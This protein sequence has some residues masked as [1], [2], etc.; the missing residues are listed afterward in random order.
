MSM[1]SST[2]ERGATMVEFAVILPLLLMLFL[3]IA[4][5]GRALLFKQRLTQAVETGARYAARAFGSVDTTDCTTLTSWDAVGGV[6]D[7]TK[8]MVAFG[9]VTGGVT[10]VIPGLDTDDVDVALLSPTVTG[11][12]VVCVVQV[13]VNALP[14]QGI[15]GTSLI[16]LLNID[17]PTLSATS[18]ER[19]V[20]E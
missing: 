12:G 8:N 7:R 5:L 10:A 16:P 13:E 1:S 4:E 14:Y 15:F 17:Q 9:Q 19:Y 11:V 6:V 2:N 18:E 20:G 3:G